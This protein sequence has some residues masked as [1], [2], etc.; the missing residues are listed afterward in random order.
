MD[1][2]NKIKLLESQIKNLQCEL[3]QCNKA[4]DNVRKI[5]TEGQVR[6]LMTSDTVHWEWTDISN[7][8]CLHASGPRAYN[9]LYVKGFPLPHVSTLQRWCRKV[10]VEECIINSSLDFMRH[11]TNLSDDEKVCVLAFD[12]MKVMETFEYD[13][14]L[15]KVRKPSNYVQVVMARGLKKS[16]KQPVFYDFDCKMSKEIIYKIIR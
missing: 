9:H 3:A 12:E 14:T 15:D 5:F 7:A 10:R 13:T 8:L 1:Y 2:S 11:I 6:K 16:W 4:L